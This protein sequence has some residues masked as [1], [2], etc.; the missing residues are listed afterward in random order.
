MKYLVYCRLVIVMGLLIT[1]GGCGHLTK[2]HEVVAQPTDNDKLLK[3]SSFDNDNK[4]KFL[5][6]ESEDQKRTKIEEMGRIESNPAAL[7]FQ[8]AEKLFNERKYNECINVLNE[9]F[10]IDPMDLESNLL[11]GKVYLARGENENAINQ[12]QKVLTINPDSAVATYWLGLSYVRS[13]DFETAFPLLKH[14]ESLDDNFPE[15]K[16]TIAELYLRTGK[17]VEGIKMLEMLIEK[18]PEFVPSY[19]LLGTF[20]L[21]R[22]LPEEALETFGI[23]EK[24]APENPMGPYYVGVVLR[25][26]NKNE[27]AKSYFEKAL[28][29]S[30]D[31]IKALEELI[32]IELASGRSSAALERVKL[33]IRN[34][35]DSA[36][37]QWVLGN[38]YFKMDDFNSA[39]TAYINA[40]ELN[41]DH[42]QA[43]VN[44]SRIFLE[45]GH[46]DKAI[47]QFDKLLEKTTN[48]RDA[49]MI[50]MLKAI[51]LESK[52]DMSGAKRSYEKILSSNPSHFQA[53]NN[54][55]Y[56]YS[57][58]LGDTD[59][60]YTWAK[61]AYETAPDNP[62]IMDTLGW[63]LYKKKEYQQALEL[64]NKSVLKLGENPEVL[65][66]LGMVH[67]QL[68]NVKLARQNIERA[69]E[70]DPGFRDAK[71]A[72]QVLKEL[73]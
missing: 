14:A 53:A 3:E 54:L 47:Q 39:R 45:T 20:Y 7:K 33:Q 37:L 65:F 15:P 6:I 44:L 8:T 38:V 9:I 27:E 56:L 16:L 64:L 68:G 55:A 48:D 5:T 23:I 63:I 51:A 22:N 13:G 35:P 11:L 60:G 71:T 12:F 62:Y 19:H 46:H 26:M 18:W 72:K 61:R 50:E 66:H 4:G 28:V 31:Y 49:Q 69:L 41:P 29:L 17:R 30:P 73:G 40:L 43:S 32:D 59:K 21:S 67:Y 34:V 24:V 52:G 58:H 10:K 42:F 1:M 70:V 36:D 2:D 25:L 57:E